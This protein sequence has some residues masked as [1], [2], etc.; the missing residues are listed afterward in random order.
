MANRQVF[1]ETS[2][3]SKGVKDNANDAKN[4]IVRRDFSSAKVWSLELVD[5][6]LR[7]FPSRER[8]WSTHSNISG[9]IPADFIVD[10]QKSKREAK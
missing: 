5:N 8:G 9:S 1:I 3:S 6:P 4:A 7:V 10:A 2:L